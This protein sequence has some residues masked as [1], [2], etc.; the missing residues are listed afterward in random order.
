MQTALNWLIVLVLC[1]IILQ[2]SIWFWLRRANDNLR[3]ICTVLQ[4]SPKERAEREAAD[5]EYAA[6]PNLIR[7]KHSPSG[8]PIYR[9]D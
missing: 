7:K 2:A 4:E 1:E 8:I 3:I 6:T 9:R 5:W